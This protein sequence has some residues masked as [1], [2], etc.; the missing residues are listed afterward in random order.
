[1]EIRPLE[2][3][4]RPGLYDC[5]LSPDGLAT[6]AVYREDEGHWLGVWSTTGCHPLLNVDL[7]GDYVRPRFSPDGRRLAAARRGDEVTVWSL[8]EGRHLWTQGREGGEPFVAHAFGAA[9]ETIALAQGDRVSVWRVEDGRW[10]Y[11]LPAPA[12]ISALRVSSDGRL[13]AVGLHAGGALIVELAGR[14]EVVRL[15][16][17]DRGVTALAFHPSRPWLLTATAPAFVPVG[18]AWE[19]AGHGWAQVWNYADGEEIAR[20]ACDYQAVLLGRG[21]Y[22]GLLT[23]DSR[24][25]AVWRIEPTTRLV[26]HIEN[27]VPELVV[28][29][30]G[31]EVRQATLAATPWG[32]LL[33]VAGLSRAI[34]AAGVLRLFAFS[35]GAD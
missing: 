27:V 19:R 34:V 31:R 28:D 3:I 6:A 26:A 23:A 13:L 2:T 29:E 1:M 8:S 7:P 18:N 24:S 21:Q 4:T 9:G 22:V 30:Q 17:I 16:A 14:E 15:P 10:L 20:L 11:A 25:L 32:D 35:A 33:A 12:A 5:D